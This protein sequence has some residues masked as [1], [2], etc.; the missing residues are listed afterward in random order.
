MKAILK[1]LIR[2]SGYMIVRAPK[3]STG[4]SPTK[5][6]DGEYRIEFIRHD[7]EGNTYLVP[8]YAAYRSAARAILA[9]T[10]YEPDTHRAVRE[11]MSRFPGAMVHAGTFFGDML[12]SFSARAQRV[13][14]FEPALENF[15]LA[16]LCKDANDLQNVVLFNAALTEEVTS[17]RINTSAPDGEHFG[18]GSRVAESGQ[19]MTGLSIDSLDLSDLSIIQLDVERHELSALKGA[20]QTI[21]TQ[22]PLVMIEDNL[23]ECDAFLGGLGYTKVADLKGLGCWASSD[24]SGDFD[25]L[26]ELEVSAD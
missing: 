7:F 21:R 10:Y 1:K 17:V 11:V 13:Y 14:A 26:K 24:R 19:L 12:P 16:N 22:R 25:F 2:S 5:G 18:G 15:V 8:R 6:N 4:A 23:A 20:E 3:G 9:D